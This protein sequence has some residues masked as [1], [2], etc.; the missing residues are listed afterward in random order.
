[1][2][3][4]QPLT[5]K[6]FY[7][8]SRYPQGEITAHVTVHLNYV[9]K[10][11]PTPP[12]SQ[13][14]KHHSLENLL[15]SH[16]KEL[17]DAD[18][19]Q[20]SSSDHSDLSAHSSLTD[21]HSDD[22]SN[23]F[24][25]AAELR[26]KLAMQGG[27]SSALKAYRAQKDFKNQHGQRSTQTTTKL[28]AY[29]SK[30]LGIEQTNDSALSTSPEPSN[31]NLSNKNSSQSTAVK[32]FTDEARRKISSIPPPPPPPTYQVGLTNPPPPPGG[33]P[34]PPPLIKQHGSIKLRQVPN[35]KLKQVHWVKVNSSQVCLPF[36]KVKVKGKSYILSK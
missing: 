8:H 1:M 5:H 3:L 19:S 10:A 22:D 33:P 29:N 20:L 32:N 34:P 30:S 16:K 27:K 4:Q 21:D 35:I 23:I 26:A 18:Q 31:D 12:K 7:F 15:F 17:K 25:S 9:D 6:K 11:L 24:G 28:K 2:L 13:R 14:G 36:C